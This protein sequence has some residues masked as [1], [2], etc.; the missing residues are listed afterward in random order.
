MTTKLRQNMHIYIDNVTE[1]SSTFEHN[2]SDIMDYVVQ[3]RFQGGP[4]QPIRYLEMKVNKNDIDSKYPHLIDSV[5]EGKTRLIID[6]VGTGTFIITKIWLN[7]YTYDIV[8]TGIEIT[9]NTATLDATLVSQI[10]STN[11]DPPAVVKTIFDNW[12]SK[13][14]LTGDANNTYATGSPEFNDDF[15]LYQSESLQPDRHG[16]GYSGPSVTNVSDLNNISSPNVGDI[17]KVTSNSKF[18]VFIG[19]DENNNKVWNEWKIQFKEN[20]PT[21]VAINMCALM[22]NAF[23]FF[24]NNNG[25]NTFYYVSYD[26]I[27]PLAYNPADMSK[28]GVVN[29]YPQMDSQYVQYTKFDL[30][31]YK[32]LIGL[33][34]KNSEGSETIINNQVVSVE[35]SRGEA[36]NDASMTMYGDNAGVMVMSDMIVTPDAQIIAENIVRRYKDPTRSITIQLSEMKTSDAGSGWE[37]AIVPFSYAYEI[38]DEVNNIHLDN[39]HLCDET[40][41]NFMLRLSTFIRAYPEMTTEYT[42]GV[43]KETTLSQE[44]ANKLTGMSGTVADVRYNGTTSIVN[45]GIVTVDATPTDNSKNPVSSDGTYDAIASAI[46]TMKTEILNTIYPVGSL[47]ITTDSRN[48]NTILGVGTW[49]SFGAGRTLVGYNASETEFNTIEKTGGEKT[50]TLTSTEMPSHGHSVSV[51]STSTEHT[52]SG[53][54][55]NQNALH[56]HWYQPSGSVSVSGGNHQHTMYGGDEGGSGNYMGDSPRSDNKGKSAIGESGSLS[57]SASF[58]GTEANTGTESAWHQHDFTTGNMSTNSSHGHTVNQSNAGGGGS[59]NNLQPYIVTYMWK[60]TA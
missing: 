9:L 34:S 60:R 24:A 28:N 32:Q 3:Y 44:L 54:T 12:R 18:Y 42:F 1:Q 4:E 33:S 8:A 20:M 51:N 21:L 11:L 53:T 30:M 41:D 35:N 36:V 39:K 26:D 38:N 19:Y 22:D 10:D 31:M 25:V 27:P 57:F 29:I 5:V 56:T 2:L 7:G 48:P 23:I 59:H 52:H 14:N 58:S 37:E 15:V 45:N 49:Q 50:H 40:T 17:Y 46:N 6:S 47:Y 55:G 16:A 43:M 13:L